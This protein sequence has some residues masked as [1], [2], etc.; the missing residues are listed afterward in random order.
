MIRVLRETHETPRAIAL[1]LARAGGLNPFGEPNFRAV[2]GWNRL[3]WIGGKWTL[4]DSQGNANGS[5]VELRREPKY[6]VPCVERW[7]VE[8][9][10]PAESYGSPESWRERTT[11]CDDGVRY[12]ALG[13]YPRRGDWELAHVLQGERG[14]FVQLDGNMAEYLVRAVI[15]GHGRRPAER[16]A[17]LRARQAE[18]QQ[19][20]RERDDELLDAAIDE[21]RERI[22]VA[23]G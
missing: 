20:A 11:E 9:W 13:P 14:E 8:R 2:W 18:Q 17:A 23:V 22:Q 15:W 5:R 10:L 3:T 12:A 4:F 16:R 6:F 7:F 19:A 21:Q 1:R